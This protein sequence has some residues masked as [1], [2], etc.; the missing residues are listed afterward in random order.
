MEG[1]LVQIARPEAD[2]SNEILSGWKEIASYMGKGVRTVQRYEM[3]LGLPVHR[4]AGRPKGSVLST[5]AELDAWIAASPIRETF[6]ATRTPRPAVSAVEAATTLRQG[7]ANLHA[8]RE[9]MSELRSELVRS[10]EKLQ[11]N[12]DI[13]RQQQWSAE[14]SSRLTVIEQKFRNPQMMRLLHV[15]D[16]DPRAS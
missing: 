14:T 1:Q 10:V 2:L 15:A 9:E 13:M 12:L 6:G 11:Q 16:Q 3:Q 7:L 5:R 8:L 4:P